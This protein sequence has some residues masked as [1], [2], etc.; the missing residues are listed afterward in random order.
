MSQYKAYT[1][2]GETN[3]PTV[4]GSQT[5]FLANVSPGDSFL[6]SGELVTY[7]VASVTDD[8]TLTLASPYQGDSKSGVAYRITRD[9]TQHYNLAEISKGDADWPAIL[10]NDTIRKID[11]ALASMSIQAGN[12]KI[13]QTLDL[14]LADTAVLPEG[15]LVW[16]N[17]GGSDSG[18]WAKLGGVLVQSTFSKNMADVQASV[19]V[20]DANTVKTELDVIATAADRVQTGLDVLATAADRVQTG[21]D[22]LATSALTNADKIQTGLDAIATAADRVQ[23]GS[24]KLTATAQAEIATTKAGEASASAAT[25]STKASEA[26]TSASAALSSK[27]A[28][29][30][31][32]TN[33]LASKNTAGVSATTATEQA[34]IA[35][36]QAGVSTTKAAEAS[37]SA[38]TASD[39]STSL[40]A[41]LVSFRATFL[42]NLDADPVVDGNGNPLV[43]GATYVN[44][45][46]NKIREYH[47]GAWYDY[48]AAAQTATINAGLSAAAAAGSEAVAVDKA[49]IATTKA[50]ESSASAAASASSSTAAS[51]QAGIATTKAAEASSKCYLRCQ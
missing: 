46:V 31:S 22:V 12:I 50:A 17:T 18:H 21:L 19:L 1:V 41:A 30:L 15:S 23:T 20:T 39:A 7:Q 2:S 35:T 11:S 36:T 16:V 26:S 44:N 34:T 14:A 51:T 45:V 43:E 10:T 40:N 47:E 49:S 38:A 28:A 5:A 13:Y 4:T 6:I 8:G 27:D 24:D 3:S 48:D 32:A 33:A 29:A 37:A 42:G 25:A 9:W